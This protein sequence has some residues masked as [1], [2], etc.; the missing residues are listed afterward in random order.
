MHRRHLLITLAIFVAGWGAAIAIFLSRTGDD[1][2]PF[3]LT[4]DG[5][6]YLY[7]TERLGGK[8]AVFIAQLNTFLKGLF[9]G[10]TLGLTIGIAA[11]VAAL[12][13]YIVATHPPKGA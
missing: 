1:A 9:Q 8:Q 2:L 4:D 7:D 5:K 13:Y 11:S 12:L 3:E 6:R 10:Q